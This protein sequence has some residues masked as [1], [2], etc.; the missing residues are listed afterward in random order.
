MYS[1]MLQMSRNRDG[2]KFTFDGSELK[3]SQVG[4]ALVDIQSAIL[5]WSYFLPVNPLT[6]IK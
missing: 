3:Q 2:D 1:P 4:K 6:H 5:P